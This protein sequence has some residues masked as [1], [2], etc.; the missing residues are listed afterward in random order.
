MWTNH[1]IRFQAGSEYLSTP[2]EARTKIRG[3]NKDRRG[4]DSRSKFMLLRELKPVKIKAEKYLSNGLLSHEAVLPLV[5]NKKEEY[6]SHEP[7]NHA[8]GD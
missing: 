2:D 3:E 8:A 7:W 4:S 1:Y 5:L 6:T